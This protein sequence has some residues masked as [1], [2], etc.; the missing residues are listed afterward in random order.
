MERKATRKFGGITVVLNY[1]LG[2][3]FGYNTPSFSIQHFGQGGE[4]MKDK[5][6]LEEMFK[7]KNMIATT[8]LRIYAIDLIK[9]LV[10]KD[11]GIGW[12]LRK[13]VEKESA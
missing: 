7:R 2:S 10:K 13:C 6:T 5:M 8:N 12:G 9:E 1:F 4:K 11:M 3:S